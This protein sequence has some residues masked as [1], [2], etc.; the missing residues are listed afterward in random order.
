MKA[1]IQNMTL[2]QIELYSDF[3]I[4]KLT[5]LKNPITHSRAFIKNIPQSINHRAVPWFKA[6]VCHRGSSEMD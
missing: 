5:G 1:P 6:K 2:N 3:P 4:K